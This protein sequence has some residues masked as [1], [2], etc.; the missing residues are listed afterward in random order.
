MCVFCAGQV[1][2]CLVVVF[3][4]EYRVSCH[5]FSMMGKLFVVVPCC[6]SMNVV[7]PL[8]RVVVVVVP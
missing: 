7:C 8:L 2:C 4:C 3:L 6:F 5:V 1:V